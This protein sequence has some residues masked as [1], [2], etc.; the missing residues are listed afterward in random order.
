MPDSAQPA[1]MHVGSALAPVPV[2]QARVV[3]LGIGNSL[4]ADDGLGVHAIRC[5]REMLPDAGIEWIDAGTLNFTLLPYFE[6][7]RALV[8]IDAA[9][10]GEPPGT[11]RVFQGDEM[12]RVVGAGRRNSVHEAGLAD[13]LAM[14]R[15]EDWLPAHRALVTVQP[16]RVD[17]GEALS[18][19]V[20]AALPGVCERARLLAQRWA[21]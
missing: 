15:L 8:V 10:L 19:P 14:A 5:L 4:L 17:W 3:V 13:L 7:A 21:E 16:Q 20:A 18:P 12:D 1:A 2:P 11:V 9:E 6:H